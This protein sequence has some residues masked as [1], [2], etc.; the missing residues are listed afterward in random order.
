MFVCFLILKTWFG[1]HTFGLPPDTLS[2]RRLFN[3]NDVVQINA[4]G[5]HQASENTDCLEND[6]SI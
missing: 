4:I 1:P 2:V 6:Y 3:L 5:L